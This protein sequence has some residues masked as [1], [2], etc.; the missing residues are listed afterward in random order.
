MLGKEKKR[1]LITGANGFIGKNLLTHLSRINL[2][3]VFLYSRESSESD[4]K[5][6]IQRSDLIVHLAGENRPFDIASFEISNVQ[7]TKK[8]CDY[9]SQSPNKIPIIFSSSVQVKNNNPYGASKLAA[10]ALLKKY[11]EKN[12]VPVI[13]FRFPGIFGKW[14]KPN[15]NSVVATFC[16]NIANGLPIALSD[17]EKKLNLCYIDDIIELIIESVHGIDNYVEFN[18]I[19]V[20]GKYLVTL[21]QLSEKIYSF[22]DSQKTLQLSHVGSGFDRALYATYVSYLPKN[23][24]FY[25]LKTKTDERGSFTEVLKTIDS[26]QISFLRINPGHSRGKHFHHTKLEKFIV[27]SGVS[28]FRFRN[29]L[30]D[31]ACEIEID[32]SNTVKV[33]ETIPGWAHEIINVSAQDLV[34]LVWSNEIFD[35]NKPDTFASAV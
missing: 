10:E 16:F 29:I 30:T 4:L 11:S 18:E 27:V 35:P 3:E 13:S 2:F 34:V 9:A 26:G 25:D 6:C 24:F 31:E 23:K 22:R 7:L 20:S 21:S 12:K 14:A 5:D 8:I 33:V 15:Y 32:G 17:K 19:N 1:I 28:K